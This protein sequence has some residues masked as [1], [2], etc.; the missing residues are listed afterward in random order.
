MLAWG[1][2]DPAY[3]QKAHFLHITSFVNHKQ[4]LIQKKLITRLQDV[5][6]SFSPGDLYIKKGIKELMPFIKKSYIIFLNQTE[7]E[8]LTG[9][10]YKEAAEKLVSLGAHTIAVT[11]G[12]MGCYVSDGNLHTPSPQ[13][14]PEQ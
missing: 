11:L 8:D 4:M 12:S 2:I 7:A 10:G 9:A 13:P 1:D 6:I 14:K 3:A 5:M